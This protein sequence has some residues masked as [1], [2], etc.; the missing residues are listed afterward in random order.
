MATNNCDSISYAD[1][2]TEELKVTS[3]VLYAGAN[4]MAVD[5]K[6]EFKT[7]MEKRWELRDPRKTV[8][9]GK[10]VTKCAVNFFRKLKANCQDEFNT[11]WKCIDWGDW[12]Y[13]NCRKEQ[14]VFDACVLEKLGI[15]PQ[16][17]GTTQEGAYM[18]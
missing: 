6:D 7:F 10:D 8:E 3:A 15:E 14:G 13:G 18:K 11:Y 17:Y 2:E 4:A 5:C 16:N 12:Q 1:L 9:E